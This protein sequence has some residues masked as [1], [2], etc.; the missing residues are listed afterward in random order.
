MKTLIVDDEIVC[1]R[2]ME[3]IMKNYGDCQ[4]VETGEEAVA[5]FAKAW[6]DWS[7][8]ALIMLDVSMPGMDG[9][10]T[11][12]QIRQMET[13]KNVSPDHRVRVIMTTAR[14][15]KSTVCSSIQAGCDGYIIKPFDQE[16]VRDE[17]A[18]L[19]HA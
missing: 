14:S 5:A 13:Q 9:T 8:F 10:E 12:F 16:K 17:L 1:R 6:E 3:Y 15:D 2:K 11:L 19:W 7:P 4:A 18:K